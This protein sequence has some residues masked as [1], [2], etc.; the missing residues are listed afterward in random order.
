MPLR[1]YK[2]SGVT[3]PVTRA[4]CA[5]GRSGSVQ[6]SLVHHTAH[7][8]SG[9]QETTFRGLT[10]PTRRPPSPVKPAAAAG[11][12]VA[13]KPA[14]PGWQRS[15]LSSVA[16]IPCRPSPAAFRR[17]APDRTPNTQIGP[18]LAQIPSRPPRPH[19]FLPAR[20]GLGASTAADGNSQ[21]ARGKRGGRDPHRNAAARTRRSGPAANEGVA[22]PARARG[23]QAGP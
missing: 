15:P 9:Q 20:I 6:A 16:V 22:D 12:G 17:S 14:S 1:S 7:P 18:T 23:P 11:F 10:R 3:R 5:Q 19:A 2:G 13:F 8:T 4:P 21:S